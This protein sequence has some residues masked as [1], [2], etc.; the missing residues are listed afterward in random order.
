MKIRESEQEEYWNR[1]ADKKNFPTPFKMSVFEEYVSPKDSVL[2]VGCGYGRI[3]NE[4]CNNEYQNLV[5]IDF[6]D[7][8]L[9][10][11]LRYYPHFDFVQGNSSVLPFADGTFHAVILIAVL[12]CIPDTEQQQQIMGEIKRVLKKGGILYL[13]DCMIN[14]DRR[15]TERYNNY[16]NKYG[17]Y[18]VFELPE[19][20]VLRHHTK[21]HIDQVS[22]GFQQMLFEQGRYTTMNGNETRGFCY[23]G[24]KV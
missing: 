3:M 17:V 18:G 11:G 1:V 23:I 24:R 5:G 14:E 6:A 22:N 8:M 20:A 10:R 15:N 7:G 13:H 16:I 19:G 2:D 4:L 9:K 21:E 12:T